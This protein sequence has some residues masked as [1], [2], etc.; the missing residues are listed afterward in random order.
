MFLCCLLLFF[1][2]ISEQFLPGHFACFDSQS[3]T[4]MCGAAQINPMLEISR[5]AAAAARAWLWELTL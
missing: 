3:A 2:D 1:K 5:G 4:M